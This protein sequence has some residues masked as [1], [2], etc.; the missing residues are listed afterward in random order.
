MAHPGGSPTARERLVHELREYL[1]IAAYL[2]VCFAALLFYRW[3]ILEEAGPAPIQYGLAAI[4]ALVLGKFML[5]GRVVGVGER[6][7]LHRPMLAV[8]WKSLSTLALLVLLTVIEHVLLG[9]WHGEGPVQALR[10]ALGGR[11]LETA[12]SCLLMGM[13]LIPWFGY[14]EIAEAIGA[15]RLR[16]IFLTP[17]R[18]DAPGA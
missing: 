16:A 18:D 2:Y 15:D 7:P 4:K 17:R 14:R 5:L 10:A 13:I 6:S 3:S 11:R 9:W 1:A 8:L 12:A